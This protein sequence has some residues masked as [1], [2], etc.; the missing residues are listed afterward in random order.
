VARFAPHLAGQLPPRSLWSSNGAGPLSFPTCR[1][2][3]AEF[4]SQPP[5]PSL[6]TRGRSCWPLAGRTSGGVGSGKCA[7][8]RRAAAAWHAEFSEA[9][10]CFCSLGRSATWWRRATPSWLQYEPR[11]FRSQAWRRYAFYAVRVRR[12]QRCTPLPTPRDGL[13][14]RRTSR[15]ASRRQSYGAPCVTNK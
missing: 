7:H 9:R 14:A 6:S 8:G 2:A 1:R 15:R 13:R 3:E 4:R 5:R 12:R 10:F 11:G